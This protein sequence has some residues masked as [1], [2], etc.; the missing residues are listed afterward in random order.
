MTTNVASVLSLKLR[1]MF[2]ILDAD[3]DGHLTAEDMPALAD[4]LAVPFA[5]VPDKMRDLRAALSNIWDA[6]LSQMAEESGG[7]LSPAGYERGV[8]VAI[9]ED[10]E[11]LV[12]A[13]NDTVVAWFAL[14]DTDDDGLISRE[15]YVQIGG[16]LGGVSVEEMGQAFDRLDHDG[17]GELSIE[18]IRTAAAEYFTSD[19]PDADGNWLYGPL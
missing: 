8:R 3:R 17:D 9:A 6:H 5:A 4:A 10:G 13:L 18:E 2:D 12:E 7:R 16:P 14:F 11:S 15:E 1:R 19:N